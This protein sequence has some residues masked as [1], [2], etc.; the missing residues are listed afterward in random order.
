M[1][2]QI[3]ISKIELR[4]NYKSNDNGHTPI[5]LG[6]GEDWAK[7]KYSSWEDYLAK[8]ELEKQNLRVNRELEFWNLSL[9]DKVTFTNN[10]YLKF[11]SEITYTFKVHLEKKEAERQE[12]LD[13]SEYHSDYNNQY[14]SCDDIEWDDIDEYYE[15]S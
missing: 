12:Y 10:D 2:T 9:K 3:N 5:V 15:R 6:W 7:G 11:I 4:P 1:N 14:D 13:N 8:K